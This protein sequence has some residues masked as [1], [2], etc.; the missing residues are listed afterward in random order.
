MVYCRVHNSLSLVP[1][2]INTVY[3][4]FNDKAA[5]QS[6]YQHFCVSS[7]VTNAL[8]LASKNLSKI[9]EIFIGLFCKSL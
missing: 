7:S 3:V 8:K 6:H 1:T 5:Q 2:L 9:N 4:Y